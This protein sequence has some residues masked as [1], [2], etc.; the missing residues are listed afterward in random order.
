MALEYLNDKIKGGK[1]MKNKLIYVGALL[2][3]GLTFSSCADDFLDQKNTH[4]LSQETFFDSA[5]LTPILK[6]LEGMVELIILR[7]NIQIIFIPIQILQRRLFLRVLQKHGP[8]F[9]VS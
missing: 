8:H 6:R 2:L 1:N 7:L 4:Q 9:I 3:I 5:T